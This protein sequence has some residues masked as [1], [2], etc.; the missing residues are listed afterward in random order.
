MDLEFALLGL[1]CLH[2]GVSG[3]DLNRI[4]EVSTGYFL[5]SSLSHIYRS[6]KKLRK[7]GLVS[8]NAVP[9]D[10]RPSKKLYQITVA[11]RE[12]L[13]GWLREPIN[14]TPLSFNPFCLKMAFSPLM[15]YETILTHIDREIEFRETMKDEKRRGIDIEMD[16][17]DKD[18]IDPRKSEILWKGINQVNTLTEDLRLDWLREFRAQVEMVRDQR[19]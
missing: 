1:I 13:D 6:L 11:G 5:S 15:D 12:A 7:K 17:L 2:S 10:N 19:S 9:I 3:Y 14:S 4:M 8:Y 16:F 18:Q